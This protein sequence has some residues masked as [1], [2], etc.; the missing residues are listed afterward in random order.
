MTHIKR[1]NEINTTCKADKNCWELIN[2]LLDSI[3]HAYL[4]TN[5]TYGDLSLE[6]VDK[7]EYLK[8]L[9]SQRN[10]SENINGYRNPRTNEYKGFEYKEEPD[11]EDSWGM[12]ELTK[13]EIDD[14][15]AKKNEILA[16]LNELNMVQRGH[17]VVVYDD[18]I[19]V[20]GI[21]VPVL[22]DCKSIADET[23]CDSKHERTFDYFAFYL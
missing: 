13:K 5:G 8:K 23:C 11:F 18:E 22:A 20:Y 15:Y 17:K 19:A 3:D 6:V 21:N 16:K 4:Q 2:L 14:F 1:I 12:S 7:V 9:R 10:I